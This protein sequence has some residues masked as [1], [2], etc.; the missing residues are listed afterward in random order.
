MLL[1]NG[2]H[3]YTNESI[4]PSDVVEHVAYGRSVSRGQPRFPELS[5]EVYGAGQWRYSYQSHDLIE[6]GGSNPGY[7]TQVTRFPNDNLGIITLSNDDDVG[8]FIKEA[9]KFRIADEILGLEEMDWND[10]YEKQWNADVERLQQVTPRPA[11]PEPPSAPFTSLAR[12]SFSHPAYGILQP[13]LVP[14]SVSSSPDS[15]FQSQHC[16]N[17]LSSYPVQRILSVSDLSIP[18]YIISWKRFFVTHLRLT[19]F[20]ENL[21]NVTVIWSN[22]EVREKEGYFDGEDEVKGDV[23]T[24]LDEKYEVEWVHGKNGKEEEG[25]AFKGGFWGMEGLDARSP[26]G[27]GKES[28]EVWF[29]GQQ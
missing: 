10:R 12:E 13:C 19:H 22:A 11:T 24:G 28:A 9:V 4:I 17:L 1:N 18:T 29:T 27:V 16:T 15:V 3:P 5:P 14:A 21:F 7:K 20:N 8:E 23:L 2:H 25:L 6:H 26:G